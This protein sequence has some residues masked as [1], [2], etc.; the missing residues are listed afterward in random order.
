MTILVLAA[1]ASR[2]SLGRAVGALLIALYVVFVAVHL[3]L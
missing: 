3:A 1:L 2:R